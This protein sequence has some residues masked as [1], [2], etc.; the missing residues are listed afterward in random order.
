MVSIYTGVG[1][2]TLKFMNKAKKISSFNMTDEEDLK[3]FQSDL[4]YI[5][6]SA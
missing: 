2:W 1:F 3:V 5:V 6:W 4:D